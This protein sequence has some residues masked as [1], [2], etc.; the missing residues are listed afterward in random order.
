MKSQAEKCRIFSALHKRE[1]AFIIPNPWD[2]GSAR[3]LASTGFEALATTSVGY[4][5]SVGRQD[6]GI[7][8]DEMIAHVT[9]L[10]SST[11]LPVS[12]DLENGFGDDPETVAET[13]R[14]AV[15]AGLAGCSIEDSSNGSGEPIYEFEHAVER[16]RAAVDVVRTL[17]FPF[18]L[19]A[20]AENFLHG[21]KD[22]KDTIRRLQAFQE[23]GANVLYAPGMTSMEDIATMVK[24]VNLPVNVLAGMQG[25]QF[26]ADEL[27]RVGVKRISVGGALTRVALGAFLRAAREMKE[28]G[29]FSFVNEPISSGEISGLLAREVEG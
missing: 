28:H 22:L 9:S 27:S 25:I 6:H 12:A 19:T 1:T 21:R 3:L 23:A 8:R 14:M 15:G 26:N 24:S 16:V 18:M 13:V 5:F 29:T 7:A 20:R 2:I 11:D 4:A 17:P 10:A